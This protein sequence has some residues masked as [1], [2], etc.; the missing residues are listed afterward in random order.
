MIR[1]QQHIRVAPDDDAILA[2][3]RDAFDHPPLLQQ[4]L[5]LPLPRIGGRT[6]RAAKI[7]RIILP[8]V[9][10][11]TGFHI[12]LV[13]PAVLR[14]RGDN[15]AVVIVILQQ[16][17]QP[18]AQLASAAAEFPADGDNIHMIALLFY[19][20]RRKQR[21]IESELPAAKRCPRRAAVMRAFTH[22]RFV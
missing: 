2:Q 20:S 8:A 16:I 19:K 12:S 11:Q 21:H 1:L 6:E 7:Q 13:Q 18:L 17:R 5:Y 15:L 10:V 22:A 9:I 3:R 14:N 4:Q